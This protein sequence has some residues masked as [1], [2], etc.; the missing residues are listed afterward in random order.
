MAFNLS[1]PLG[2]YYSEQP[3]VLRFAVAPYSLLAP[4]RTRAA[5]LGTENFGNIFLPLPK[6]PGYQLSHEFGEGSNPVGPQISFAS[7]MNSGGWDNMDTLFNRL[8]A[9]GTF[10]EEYMYATSTFRRF[11]N[12]T[13]ATMVSE[14]RKE[15]NFEYIFVPKNQYESLEVNSIVGSFRKLSYPQVADG[16]PER[17][18]P[19][20]L[21]AL[22]VLNGPNYGGGFSEN[23][24]ADWLGEPLPLVLQSVTVKQN[25]RSDSIVRYLPSGFSNFTLLALSFI[26]FETGSMNSNGALRSKS[27]I[28]NDE[29]S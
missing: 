27:E 23:L 16:L 9:K 3:L 18:Y 11:T 21:W 29:L 5:I 19:Q 22:E 28:A 2:N 14:A 1:Y 24:T 26:E 13:E 17:S 6:E 7:V 8:I 15:Y 12:I 4:K 25:D 10:Q 20:N